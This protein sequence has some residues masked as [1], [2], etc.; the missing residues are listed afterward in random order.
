MK[1]S[2]K[3]REYV[4]GHTMTVGEIENRYPYEN[5]EIDKK[6]ILSAYSVTYDVFMA[7]QWRTKGYELVSWGG[8]YHKQRIFVFKTNKKSTQLSMPF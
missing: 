1:I 8:L 4:Y 6:I 3:D 2:R 7:Y 5:V